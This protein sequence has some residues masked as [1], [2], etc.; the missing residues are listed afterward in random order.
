[1]ASSSRRSRGAAAMAARAL[2]LSGLVNTGRGRECARAMGTA[3][4]GDWGVVWCVVSSSPPSRP[5]SFYGRKHRPHAE[6]ALDFP[7]IFFL[8]R[9]RAN[10]VAWP[11]A[12]VHSDRRSGCAPL[13]EEPAVSG[14]Q[15]LDFALSL[16]A[17]WR[18]CGVKPGR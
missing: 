3:R 18:R 6:A 8:L 16:W 4:C 17:A 15:R 7:P 14:R 1:M 10:T 9:L 5:P 11:S 13:G 12:A 2:E